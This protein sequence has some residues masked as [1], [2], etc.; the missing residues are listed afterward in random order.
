MSRNMSRA[1]SVFGT[2]IFIACAP[3]ASS[4]QWAPTGSPCYCMRPVA[5]TIYRTVPVTQ[6]Q[7]VRHTVRKPVV[8]TK[9]VE[10][11]VTEY[12]RVV[13]AKTVDVPTLA[14]QDITEHRTIRRNYGRWVTRHQ[15]KSR[16]SACE[17]DGRP[18]IFGFLNRTGY[19][20]RSAF[21]PRLIAT[22]E[23]V[24]NVQMQTI[25]VTR[26]VA[27]HGTRKVTYNV[28]RLDPHTTT[29]K[30]AV[31]TVRYVD[32]EVVSLRPVT[33]MRSLPVGTRTSYSYSPLTPQLTRSALRPSPDPI[34]SSKSQTKYPKRTANS[35]DDDDVFAPKS[36]SRDQVDLDLES[37]RLG[38]FRTDR[39]LAS[40]SV[41][42]STSK[43][44]SPITQSLKHRHPPTIRATAQRVPS[45]VRVSGWRARRPVVPAP[46]L[47]TPTISIAGK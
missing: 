17:Y 43:S 11:P 42:R 34:S 25:P 44:P 28:T 38:D 9:Y 37:S 46:I 36:D 47:T 19:V 40:L 15:S 32:E 2:V 14:Y 5:Q 18:D 30:V 31:N 6:Y 29:R 33:V 16:L 26:R 12:R 13:E 23:Y 8:E 35:R 27:I 3:T 10:R 7:E 24:P 41:R 21:T 20:I 1:V 22:R 45:I 4:A 39:T